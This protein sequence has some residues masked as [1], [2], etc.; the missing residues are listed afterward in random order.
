MQKIVGAC[1]ERKLEA[2]PVVVISNNSGS[3]ALAFARRKGIPTY[4]LSSTTHPDPENLDLAI[5]QALRSHGTQLVLLVGYNKL[6]GPQTLDAY[7]GRILNTHP[8]PL[9][10]FGGKGMYG[11]RVH[12]AVLA[13]GIEKTAVSI[14]LVDDEYDH[15]P[16]V[17]AREID[18]LAGDTPESLAERVRSEEG[19]FLIESLD[20]IG[21]GEIAL[22]GLFDLRTDRH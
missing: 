16:V 7:R 10:E 14:H 11:K 12:E 8:A 15:G 6:V 9:P 1:L 4:H 3:G 19:T 2:E 18:V 20:M 22:P 5:C 13:S 17:A 21:R